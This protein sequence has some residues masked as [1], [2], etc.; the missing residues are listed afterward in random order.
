MEIFWPYPHF[1]LV[2]TFEGEISVDA[3][4]RSLQNLAQVLTTA[5]T[6]GCYPLCEVAKNH[7]DQV[8]ST[9]NSPEKEN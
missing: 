4:C 1:S 7:V 6:R 3:L 2:R 8:P 5:P 9:S